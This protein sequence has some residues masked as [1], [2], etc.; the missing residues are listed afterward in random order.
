MNSLL[1]LM[2]FMAVFNFY[3]PNVGPALYISVF[4]SCTY[5][6]IRVN[7]LIE[8]RSTVLNALRCYLVYFL[9]PFIFLIFIISIRTIA[10]GGV[11][12]S[13]VFLMIKSFIF[14]I[15]TLSIPLAI[16]CSK[17][18]CNDIFIFNK[19]I[20]IAAAVQSLII[21]CAVLFPSVGEI[22]KI[23]QNNDSNSSSLV[24][25]GLRGIALS[26]M[27]Y[28]GLACFYCLVLVFLA[29]DFVNNKVSIRNTSILLILLSISAIFVSRTSL[30]GVL[31]FWAYLLNPLAGFSK[32]RSC[33]LL[34]VYSLFFVCTLLMAL[35][36][37]PDK[38]IIITE[39]VLPWAFEFIYRYQEN[40]SIST[41]S[42]DQ[43]SQ[44]Y[45]PLSESTLI[46]GDGRYAGLSQGSY[47]L[48]TDAGYM[49]PTLFSGIGL[50]VAMLLVWFFWLKRIARAEK[51]K[52]YFIFLFMLSLLLQYK[53][54]FI[55]TNYIVLIVISMQL[56]FSLLTREL[57]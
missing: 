5:L 20:Y 44:M 1:A 30:L 34:L 35:L 38:M 55:V 57:D 2:L 47:Y 18:K 54:E 7:K 31:I 32:R 17:Y 41:A 27:Q 48:D 12:S 36:I 10:T 22:V 56:F 23:F 26:S 16:F 21:I 49:R 8:N 39:K 11:D 29:N 43:L 28:Y 33:I 50:M 40:G 6:F 19:Y 51:S 25:E 46:F 4:I 9:I 3:I 45:F 24:S 52:Y 53:G 37:V 15:L 13:Y 42:T 14:C